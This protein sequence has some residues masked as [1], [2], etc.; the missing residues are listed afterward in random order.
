MP[1]WRKGK[2]IG[3]CLNDKKK[4][5]LNFQGFEDLC[6]KRGYEV[7]EIDLAKPL[8]EQ[9]PFD[10]II[11]KLSDLILESGY[12][13]QSHQLIRDFQTYV[14]TYSSIILLDPFP[15]VRPLLDR[16]ESYRLLQDLQ[17]QDSCIF[18]PPYV[19]LNSGTEREAAAWIR[20]QGLTFP[21]ICKTRVAHGPSSHEMAL[22]F[23]E[24]GLEEVSAPC[25][26]QSFINHDAV[27]FKVFVVGSS[28]FVVRR[29]SLKNFPR[30]ESARKS[31]FFNS[32][33]VSKPESCSRLTE[34]DEAT[35]EPTPPSDN[36]V[37]RAVRGLR[38]ALGLSL[39]GLDLIV[40][41]QTGRCAVIDV[42]AFPGYE[43]VP[44]FFSALLNHIE[45]LLE[46]HE[47]AARA[48]VLMA[49]Y[50]LHQRAPHVDT[51]Q[52][53]THDTD[54]RAPW[55]TNSLETPKSAPAESSFLTFTV[56]PA[57]LSRH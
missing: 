57:M 17:D 28:H 35:L 1:S 39:F 46:S 34:L 16:F 5:K 13:S 48:R 19:E 7:T 30:G 51:T 55:L 10:V 53:S 15:A 4:K 14:E 33:S 32:C 11:H 37:C 9:G 50:S 27:L 8:R 40:E 31:I 38:S 23:N 21:L 54:P 44:E 47:Q 42:N 24:E 12:N 45:T 43:G 25:L 49:E 41:K 18:F 36:V 6:R 20:E 29:P 26:L 22:I 52:E 56:L 2:R 3:Y